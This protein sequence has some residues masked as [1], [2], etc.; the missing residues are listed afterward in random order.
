MA[1]S[2]N[3]MPWTT[4]TTRDEGRSCE[5]CGRFLKIYQRSLSSAMAVAL[6]RLHHLRLQRIR[7]Q[8]RPD[9]TLNLC[10][11]VR[12]F[13]R[14]DGRGEV[15]KLMCWGLVVEIEN[16]DTRKRSS[17]LWSI[18]QLGIRFVRKQEFV[19]K[20]VLLKWGTRPLGTELLG[21]AGPAVTIVDCLGEKFDYAALMAR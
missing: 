12:D 4:Q 13:D 6:I 5:A 18:T 1:S 14:D 16:T 15:S 19:P 11:H 7:A 20:Y 8:R 21:F 2:F 17:G 10:F 3:S 9:E